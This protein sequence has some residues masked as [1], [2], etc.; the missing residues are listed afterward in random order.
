MKLRLLLVSTI[1]TLPL[2]SAC[3]GPPGCSDNGT[4]DLV[5]KIATDRLRDSLTT[6]YSPYAQSMTYAFTKDQVDKGATHLQRVIDQVD[7]EVAKMRVEVG[8]IRSLE[9]GN[10]RKALCASSLAVS[11]PNGQFDGNIEYSAQ[12]SDDGQTLHVEVQGL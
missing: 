10:S 4:V 1:S 8:G 12:F 5:K 11:G 9:S 3:G 7:A 6:R 2:L